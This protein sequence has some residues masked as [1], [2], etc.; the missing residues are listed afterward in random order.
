MTCNNC[1]STVY[2]DFLKL[3]VA[4]TTDEYKASAFRANGESLVKCKAC[5]LVFVYPFTHSDV[6]IIDGYSNAI[7][8]EYVSQIDYRIRTFE[9]C[10]DKVEKI[11]GLNT[12]SIL[13]LGAAAG[14]FVKVAKDRGWQA[15]G[16]EPCG[17]LTTWAINNLG[18]DTMYTGTLDDFSKNFDFDIITMWDVLEHVPDPSNTV[19]LAKTLLKDGGYIVVNLPDISAI[20]PRLMK[21]RWPFY[22]SCHL[23]YYVPETIDYLMEKHGFERVH[24]SPHWQELS[25]GYLAYRFE[26]FS[27]FIS[28]IMVRFISLF[29]LSE[30]PIKYNI[31][32]T[33]YVYKKK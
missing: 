16:V 2:E 22:A 19:A 29:G 26:Q 9:K 33:L 28:K 1:G 6:K 30:V 27:P 12:G 25:L 3:P 13:D 21:A 31:G 20:L 7:D 23:Y 17:F 18:L 32:Q 8:H 10:M 11:T 14:A 4:G 24:K 15:V 5:G